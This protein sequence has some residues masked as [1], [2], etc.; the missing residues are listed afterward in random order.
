MSDNL[1]R[2]L[3]QHESWKYLLR[4]MEDETIFFKT[5]L[6]GILSHHFEKRHLGYLEVFQH[7]FL[8]MDEQIGLLR[9]EVNELQEAVQHANDTVVHPASVTALREMMAVKMDAIQDSFEV[10]AADFNMYL[11]KSFPYI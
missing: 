2:N 6:A 9:H 7:R 8:K 4:V 3:P 1:E 5:K 10:L 11:Q